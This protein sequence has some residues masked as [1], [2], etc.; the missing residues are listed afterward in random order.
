MGRTVE[1]GI[2]VEPQED[3][4]SDVHRRYMFMHT[5]VDKFANNKISEGYLQVKV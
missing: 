4:L 1:L 5:D 3:S 2:G